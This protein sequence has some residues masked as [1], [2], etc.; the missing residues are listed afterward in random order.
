MSL[1]EKLGG[2]MVKVKTLDG[3]KIYVFQL[4]KALES[5]RVFH[6]TIRTLFSSIAS[7]ADPDGGGL[8]ISNIGTAMK[9]LDFET[10]H[11]LAKILLRGA[12]VK[13]D[14]DNLKKIIPIKNLDDCDYFL[15]C[16]EEIYIAVYHALRANYPK[17]FSRLASK[18]GDFGHRVGEQMEKLSK[19]ASE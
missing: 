18:L 7:V 11:E 3:E 5:Q 2:A 19:A 1:T 9:M 10:F 15:D 6:E 17:S 16:P 14:P 8:N 12:T 13:P 4:M